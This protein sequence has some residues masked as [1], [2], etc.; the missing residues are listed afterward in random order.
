MASSAETTGRRLAILSMA[1]SA[2][3]A[4][5]KISIGWIANSTAVVSDG[6]E[7]AGDV[8]A[9]GIVFIGFLLA[10]RPADD[11]HPYGHGRFETLAGLAVG[12]L[13]TATG[14][15]ICI[16]SLDRIDEVHS[17]P[18]AYA[19]WPLLLSIGAKG[20]LSVVKMRAGRRIGSHSLEADAWNDRLDILS[21][22]VAL[23]AVSLAVWKPDTLSRADHFGG[24][25][26]GLLVIYLGL[27]VV[28]ETVLSL[29]DTMPDD[30]AMQDIRRS[31]LAEPGAL[32]VEKCFARKTGLRF[33][34][35]LHLE[36]DPNLTVRASHDI[37][38]RV[39]LRI[40]D[41]LPWVADVLVHVEPFQPPDPA[42]PSRGDASPQAPATINS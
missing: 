30:G 36:V 1:V 25:A 37:A 41:Q 26:V 21:G 33:H 3:L 14:V 11:D 8:L 28:R 24:F 20:I 40:R 39:R 22:V 18:G 31:A 16:K 7:S 13:L 42:P 32:A 15:G 19:I 6:F 34:V 12:M 2:M 35:D 29:M 5:L 10:S 17:I 4:G 27:R 9:S 23:I 38:H